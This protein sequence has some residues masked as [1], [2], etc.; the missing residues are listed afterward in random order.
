MVIELYHKVCL[1]SNVRW[2]VKDI[3]N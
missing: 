2:G 1:S 3:K